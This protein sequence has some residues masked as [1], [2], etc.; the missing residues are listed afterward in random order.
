MKL[1]FKYRLKLTHAQRRLLGEHLEICRQVYNRTLAAR[2]EA[3]E[4]RG[5]TLN[6]YDTAKCLPE[7]KADDPALEQVHS[8]VLQNV[9]K[10]VEL[11]FQAFFRRVQAGEQPGYP[12]FRG[13]GWYDSITYPQYGNGVHLDGEWLRLS[14]IGAIRV[15][16]HRPI[17]GQIKTVT[18]QRDQFGNW[19]A[20]F[21][22]DV[23]P[24]PLPPSDQVVGIDLGLKTFATL[25]DGSA[26]RRERWMKRDADDIARLQRKKERYPK[27]SP[28]RR[29]VIR[30]L[31]HAYRRAA[32]RRSNFA[33]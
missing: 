15:K 12:R 26:I 18:L 1:T 7:W 30:A 21:A 11:A 27:G 5:E 8:Q 16:L 19:Y 10:R 9:Q 4:Q 32:N 28:A 25:S 22:C 33:H 2:Q 29:K 13:A 24:D 14:K 6:Y 20:C 17:V 31:Q 3:Y 23:E